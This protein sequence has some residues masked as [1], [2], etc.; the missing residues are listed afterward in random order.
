MRYINSL[1]YFLL[2]NCVRLSITICLHLE[3]RNSDRMNILE[4]LLVGSCSLRSLVFR[5]S[6]SL[7]M[8]LWVSSA[9]TVLEVI[10]V[11]FQISNPTTFD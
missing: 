1:H 6:S 7:D 4:T 10:Q 5:R 2:V 11:I 9:R 8:L 3:G